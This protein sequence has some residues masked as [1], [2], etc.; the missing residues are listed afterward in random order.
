MKAVVA[1]TIVLATAVLATAS[2]DSSAAVEFVGAPRKRSEAVK[3]FNQAM[4]GVKKTGFIHNLNIGP[5]YGEPVPTEQT[6]PTEQ[7]VRTTAYESEAR[8]RFQAKM[9]VPKRVLSVRLR[10]I[11]PL[12]D[13]TRIEY[14][15]DGDGFTLPLQGTNRTR[16][17][18]AGDIFGE[19][20]TVAVNISSYRNLSVAKSLSF[21]IES[22]AAFSVVSAS[23]LVGVPF[24]TVDDDGADLS[25]CSVYDH[26]Q[27]SYLVVFNA[28]ILVGFTS[29]TR[30]VFACASDHASANKF[31]LPWMQQFGVCFHPWTGMFDCD[32]FHFGQ[33]W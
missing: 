26:D 11:Q 24:E 3:R 16:Q 7:P 18:T 29:R 28:T 10:S 6:E 31:G 2:A 22:G 32:G 13:G 1:M 15:A 5:V 30:T 4:S 33:A 9:S 25:W 17:F 8:A 20:Q 23:D 12:R 19:Q 27:H 14:T 21:E